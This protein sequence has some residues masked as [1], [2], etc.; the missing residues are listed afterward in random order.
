MGARR[1]FLMRGMPK[2][3]PHKD[4]KMPPIKK[5]VA[6]ATPPPW[7]KKLP[8]RRKNIKKPPYIV[9]IFWGI[10]HV[11]RL[12]ILLPHSL[13]APMVKAS[14]GHLQMYVLCKLFKIY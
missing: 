12:P 4:K 11:E 10:F 1:N 13:R 7:R 9:K 5:N 14:F 2:K 3:D 8:I 6:K